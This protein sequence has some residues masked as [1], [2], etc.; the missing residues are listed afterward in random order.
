MFIEIAEFVVARENRRRFAATP[1]GA[2]PVV[3]PQNDVCFL[4]LSL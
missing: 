2:L 4:G 3:A 1:L